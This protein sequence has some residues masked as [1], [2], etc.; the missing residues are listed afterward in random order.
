MVVRHLDLLEKRSAT[1]Q[2]WFIVPAVLG[3][4]AALVQIVL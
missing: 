4:I 1:T 2:K 3:T